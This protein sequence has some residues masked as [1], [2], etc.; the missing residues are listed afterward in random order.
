MHPDDRRRPEQFDIYISRDNRLK[1]IFYQENDDYM[2]CLRRMD[3]FWDKYETVVVDK[4]SF[5]KYFRYVGKYK[6]K[7][8]WEKIKSLFIK[9]QDNAR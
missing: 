8:L 7:S 9:E 2:I 5:Y 6:E 1:I 4:E 3:C